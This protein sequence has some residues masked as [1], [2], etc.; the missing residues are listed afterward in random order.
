[1]LR[2]LHGV[3]LAVASFLAATPVTALGTCASGRYTSCLDANA[4]W[5]RPGES[6]FSSVAGARALDANVS[7][8]AG[9]SAIERPLV[10][11]VAAP[12][13][14][15]ELALVERAF[16]QHLLLSFGLS[17]RLQLGL[18]LITVLWQSGSGPAAVQS[19]TGPRI[20][21]TAVRDPRVGI[22]V[23][24]VD[25]P[26]A[27]LSL[28]ADVAAPLGDHDAFAGTGSFTFAPSATARVKTGAFIV[29]G[30]LGARLR[31]TVELGNLRHGSQLYAAAGIAVSLLPE[32]QL[33]IEGFA[34]P[35]LIDS[36]SESAE[37]LGV[38]V[39]ALPSEWLSSIRYTPRPRLTT[40]LAIGS[41][42]PSSS[43]T[44]GGKREHFLGP[45]SPEFRALLDVGYAY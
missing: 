30:E 37:K 14:G 29:G 26:E 45:T 15:R 38:S 35:S 19:Q 21:Q 27:A 22:A 43:E 41:G 16:D 7:V 9:I 36:S 2:N 4:L 34:F 28:R 13:S 5:L 11:E 31:P 32:L 44:R 33:A 24:L 42:L 3:T 10:L 6:E 8:R 39:R 17:E 1:M 25:V 23:T 18:A 40:T 12:G 20:E